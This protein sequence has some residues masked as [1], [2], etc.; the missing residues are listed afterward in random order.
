M[1]VY[2][3][4]I[5]TALPA[6]NWQQC[7]AIAKQYADFLVAAG[8][9]EILTDNGVTSGSQRVIMM[10]ILGIEARKYRIT[11]GGSPTDQNAWYAYGNWMKLDNSG[12][13]GDAST[14]QQW[15]LTVISGEGFF[16]L[17][18]AGVSSLDICL[19]VTTDKAG[20][21]YVGTTVNGSTPTILG[22]E[23]EEDRFTFNPLNIGTNV[24]L[25][26]GG[27][28][29]MPSYA[30]KTGVGV[31]GFGLAGMYSPSFTPSVS[32]KTD[33]SKVYLWSTMGNNSKMMVV[34]D[35]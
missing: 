11:G 26:N 5:F 32:V 6:T 22:L 9:G 12:V 33:G 17:Y 10:K 3:G 20:K 31:V 19:Y 24:S 7:N 25:P 14:I 13:T 2:S 29:L 23:A 1:A 21:K 34:G 27:I 15:S 4:T 18:N 16:C 30:I 8:V 28:L 35:I